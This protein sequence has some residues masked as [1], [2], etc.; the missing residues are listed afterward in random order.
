GTP[1]PSVWLLDSG[2]SSHI[3]GRKELF[4]K[5]DETQMH[6]VKLG[7]NKEIQVAGKGFIGVTMKNGET[8]LIHNVQ[9]VPNLAH[10][11]LSVGQLVGN[12]YQL[13]FK[14]G[15]CKVIDDKTGN[16]L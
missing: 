10:N 8:K 16:Q 6:V 12:G 15:R 13:I 5:L 1:E 3:T 9:F 7:D 4:Y 2:C 14:G 11:L